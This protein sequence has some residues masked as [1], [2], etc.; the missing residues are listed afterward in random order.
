MVTQKR[1]EKEE[2]AKITSLAE[3][4]MGYA[5]DSI[6]VHMRFLDI[7]VTALSPKIREN[8]GGIACDG[9]NLYY[10]PVYWLKQY[11]EDPAFAVRCYLHVLFHL[12]FYHQDMPNRFRRYLN[13]PLFREASFLPPTTIIMPAIY[14]AS[15]TR[16]LLL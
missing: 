6:L 4:I 15:C 16:C 3:Q 13:R 12:I 11:K 8:L 1:A 7:A 5:R 10:D 2:Q 9:K 14:A